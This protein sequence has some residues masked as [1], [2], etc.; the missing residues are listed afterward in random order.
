MENA[1]SSPSPAM[2]SSLFFGSS[3]RTVSTGADSRCKSITAENKTVGCQTTFFWRFHDLTADSVKSGRRVPKQEH[4]CFM[5]ERK[6][7]STGEMKKTRGMMQTARQEI[8]CDL[9]LECQLTAVKSIA[10]VTL[11]EVL[12]L[13]APAFGHDLFLR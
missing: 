9:S 12:L 5:V 4:T 10:I 3:A 7:G 2:P 8:R 6:R 1:P 13:F 11:L